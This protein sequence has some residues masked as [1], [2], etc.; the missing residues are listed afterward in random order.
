[1][2]LSQCA[3]ENVMQ[4][5]EPTLEAQML[6]SARQEHA[7][8]R[9]RVLEAQ[10]V[11]RNQGS[12]IKARWRTVA[13]LIALRSGST[14]LAQLYICHMLLRSM[15]RTLEAH[16]LE[17]DG[18]LLQAWLADP[19][20]AMAVRVGCLDRGSQHHFLAT[21][22]LV[23]SV[24]VDYIALQNAKGQLVPFH[25]MFGVYLRL[26]QMLGTEGVAARHVQQLVLGSRH[27]K[28]NW[29]REF[30]ESWPMDWGHK[31]TC[32]SLEDHSIVRRV[33]GAETG[34]NASS[35]GELPPEP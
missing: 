4:F 5:L 7:L 14:A 11:A 33:A 30:R 8:C 32:P 17:V 3:M 29:S 27:R 16:S 24:V 20:V 25:V 13:I 9:Q 22:F 31:D 35:R 12:I 6:A 34:G 28:Y 18:A 10:W 26:W 15:D 23:E 21:K 19:R 1:M 2:W